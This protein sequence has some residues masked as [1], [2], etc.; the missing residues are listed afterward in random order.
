MRPHSSSTSSSEPG[1]GDGEVS[2]RSAE[3]LRGD[4]LREALAVA[5][6]TALF[7]AAGDIMVSRLFPL[8]SDPRVETKSPLRVY[9]NY[10]WS[11]EA[12]LRREVGP[13]DEARPPR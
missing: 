3:Q 8:P 9:F 13:T 4:H 5:A 1:A 10:G 2:G 6:W 7:L 11:V 12:K